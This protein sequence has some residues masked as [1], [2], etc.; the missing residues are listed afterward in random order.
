MEIE[1]TSA[2]QNAQHNGIRLVAIPQKL[3]AQRN[4]F[5]RSIFELP[6]KGGGDDGAALTIREGE[7]Y[8]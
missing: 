4:G 2:S 8:A 6:S 7:A 3:A 5:R 1:S